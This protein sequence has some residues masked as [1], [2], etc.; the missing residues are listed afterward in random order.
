MMWGT[1]TRTEAD[2]MY[3][4]LCLEEGAGKDGGWRCI[5]PRRK[6]VIT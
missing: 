6:E 4:G 2:M 3:I 1:D 5:V